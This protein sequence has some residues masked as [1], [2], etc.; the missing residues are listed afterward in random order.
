M[1]NVALT[2]GIVPAT[3][4]KDVLTKAMITSGKYSISDDDLTMNKV[5]RE[6]QRREEELDLFA[7]ELEKEFESMGELGTS[8]EGEEEREVVDEDAEMYVD[9]IDENEDSLDGESYEKEGEEGEFY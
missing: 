7:E 8:K 4:T 1:Y 3:L 5:L 6:E 2:M 9:D